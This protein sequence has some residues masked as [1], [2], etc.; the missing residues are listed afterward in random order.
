MN[1]GLILALNFS[2]FGLQGP[3]AAAPGI[4]LEMQNLGT[5]PTLRPT[6]SIRT[7]GVGA[8]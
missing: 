8:L 2:K 7:P 3:V 5:P 4:L 6:Y 1:Y